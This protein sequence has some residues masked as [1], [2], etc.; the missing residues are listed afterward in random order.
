MNVP[1]LSNDAYPDAFAT[2]RREVRDCYPQLN[3]DDMYSSQ[4]LQRLINLTTKYVDMSRDDLGGYYRKFIAITGFLIKKGRLSTRERGI[5]HLRGFPQPV[6]SAILSRLAI[7][8]SNVRPQ[9]GYDFLDIHEAALFVLDSGESFTEGATPVILQR[10]KTPEQSQMNDLIKAM[11]NLTKLVTASVQQTSQ[12]SQPSQLSQP[13]PGGASSD[14]PGMPV[15]PSSPVQTDRRGLLDACCDQFGKV[16]HR[17]DQI[18]HLGLLGGFFALKD[19][20]SCSFCERL[21][22]VQDKESCLV[23]VREVVTILRVDVRLA[24]SETAENGGA[25]RLREA[26]EIRDASFSR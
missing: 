20:R 24:N 13:A 11:S 6:R 1:C 9:D 26:S 5:S 12:C 18:V 22:G 15:S 3:E 23:Y 25:D 19:N 10:E 16:G 2:F 8:K 4:D 21:A 7:R 14:A 17:L